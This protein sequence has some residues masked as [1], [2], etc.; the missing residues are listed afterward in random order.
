MFKPSLIALLMLGLGGCGAAIDG[1]HQDQD[2][3]ASSTTEGRIRVFQTTGG[4]GL[5]VDQRLEPFVP[6]GPNFVRLHLKANGHGWHSTFDEGRY[7]SAA[8]DAALSKM[9]ADGYNIVRVFINVENLGDG[10]AAGTMNPRYLVNLTDFVRRAEHHHVK[11]LITTQWIPASYLA[12]FNDR[13]NGI[14]GY[15]GHFLNPAHLAAQE[16]YLGDLAAHFVQQQLQD[17]IFAYDLINEG[18][19]ESDKPPFDQQQGQFLAPNGQSYDLATP[20][21][22]QELA[23][24]SAIYYA[25]RLTRAIKSAD[26]GAL[27]TLSVFS[28]EA[29]GHAGI[30]G[31]PN[32]GGDSRYPFRLL[33]LAQSRID[34][35]D[36][37]L[38]PQSEAKLNAE[39]ASLE[40]AALRTKKP[41]LVGEL[42][43]QKGVP[44]QKAASLTRMIADKTCSR[45][46]VGWLFWTWDTE[47]A[48]HSF[49]TLLEQ[50][51]ALNGVF[52]PIAN[53]LPCPIDA[54]AA[55]AHS[56]C[57]SEQGY[58]DENPEVANAV[59]EGGFASG[60]AHF[61]L[62]GKAE[63]RAGCPQQAQLD[64]RG[65]S[66]EP[67]ET[68]R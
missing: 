48:G 26:P 23:D 28:P 45:G 21:S 65:A 3:Q 46:F 15:N 66:R 30:G 44:M 6:R 14:G 53:P 10:Q 57:F 47:E 2:R 16:R 13:T 25:N 37:H 8:A 24:A 42:G 11:V 9:H 56:G 20:A 32:I 35:L 50:G 17:A 60:F 62:H 33:K 64:A 27:T 43:A 55:Q 58:L 1:A 67:V 41:L 38:Y 19:Y 51:G 29:V 7:D 49:H 40:W 5:F 61:I 34:F 54:L 52:A 59:R 68:V 12:L 22:R 4:H 18:A 31:L 39:I 63:G 36:V